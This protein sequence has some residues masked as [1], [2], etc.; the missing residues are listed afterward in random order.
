MA[1]LASG[2]VSVRS[3]AEEEEMAIDILSRESFKIKELCINAAKLLL[4][5]DSFPPLFHQRYYQ[6]VNPKCGIELLN[7]RFVNGLPP[8]GSVLFIFEPN[9]RQF[10]GHHIWIDLIGGYMKFDYPNHS[11]YSDMP[12]V[13][14]QNAVYIHGSGTTDFL[15]GSRNPTITSFKY[16]VDNETGLVDTDSLTGIQQELSNIQ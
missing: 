3:V 7:Q 8:D 12:N 4:E 5:A 6:S 11:H 16:G 9:H 1:A 13:P 15:G 2:N 14:L 10:N